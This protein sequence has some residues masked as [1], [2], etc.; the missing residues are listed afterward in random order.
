MAAGGKR[1]RP[2]EFAEFLYP[3]LRVGPGATKAELRTAYQRLAL[4][5][6]PDRNVGRE[7]AA[8][9]AFQRVSA[10]YRVLS[11]PEQ[12]AL[13]DAK[14]NVNFAQ[15]VLQMAAVASAGGVGGGDPARNVDSSR[16]AATPPPTVSGDTDAAAAAE[17]GA[18]TDDAEEDHYQPTFVAAAHALRL[19]VSAPVAGEIAVRLRRADGAE[20]FGLMLAKNS[21][22]VTGSLV[23]SPAAAADVPISSAEGGD[24][25]VVGTAAGPCTNLKE[26]AAATKDL[27]EVTLRLSCSLHHVS[28]PPQF[29]D[30]SRVAVSRGPA[31]PANELAA[32][33]VSAAGRLEA[34]EGSAQARALPA[35]PSVARRRVVAV[36]Q[37]PVQLSGGVSATLVAAPPPDEHDV[38]GMRRTVLTVMAPT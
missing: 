6:H 14:F 22:K 16:V 13:H 29:L 23:G 36:N 12:R 25:F 4:E 15:R 35:W 1:G 34:A 5:L 7:E 17:G 30:A 2:E 20:P 11:D 31:G 24:V 10:A 37:E 26:F 21:L 9:A 3:V 38:P 32:V 27:A 19:T 28:V 8:K 18:E 33:V